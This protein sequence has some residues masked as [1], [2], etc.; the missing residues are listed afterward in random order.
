MVD[1]EK[2]DDEKRKIIEEIL[3]NKGLKKP[4]TVNNNYDEY[5]NI[6]FRCSKTKR[7]FN[8]LFGKKNNEKYKIIKTFKDTDNLKSI[9][10]G[11][12]KTSL[13][14]KD[15]DIN[16]LNFINYICPHCSSNTF[17]KC[18]CSKLGCQGIV[19]IVSGQDIYTCPWCGNTGPITG[20]IKE[21]T[22]TKQKERKSL[23][24]RRQIN[25]PE[26]FKM[27]ED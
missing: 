16:D 20:Y 11:E 25:S 24:H 23:N 19:K 17:V 5:L 8:C 1:L 14:S 22:G 27:L 9:S 13:S 26:S 2:Y 18:G 7:N 6:E 10:S 15:F 3:S 12:I 21:V 4:I